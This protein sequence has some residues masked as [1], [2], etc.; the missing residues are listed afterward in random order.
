MKDFTFNVKTFVSTLLI[1][2]LA[3][4]TAGNA[5]RATKDPVDANEVRIMSFNI[6]Y[7]EFVKRIGAVPKQIGEYMPDSVG[8]QECTYDWYNTLQVLLPE[9]EIVGLGRDTGDISENCGEM[10]A[11]LYRSDKYKLV[12]SGHFW[13]SETP[14]KISNGWDGACNRIS[15]W[16]ILENLETGKQYAHVNCHL[17][18]VGDVARAEGAKLVA[19]KAL[20]F[21]IPTVLTGDFNFSKGCDE[22]NSVIELG[23][24]DTQDIATETM[25][26]KTYHGYN[27]GTSGKPIDYVFINNK[28]TSVS[29]YQIIRDKI[30]FSYVSDHYPIYA[31]M[32]I[33]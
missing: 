26:G 28:I 13:I 33:D 8:L 29:K 23:L 18:H 16:V 25:S 2:V 5:E 9:Y 19:Q 32:L 7:S 21:D 3:F 22:Y 20:S 30:N 12:D 4:I 31:D 27:G 14:E 10:S 11:I 17:D 15:T 1:I 24:K 6:R